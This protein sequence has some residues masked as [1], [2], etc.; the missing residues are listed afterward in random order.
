MNAITRPLLA[1]GAAFLWALSALAEIPENFKTS[2]LVAWCVAHRWDSENRSPAERAALLSELGIGRIA[3]NWRDADNP[4]FEA[5]ILECRKQGI[6]YFAF[7]NEN[8]DAFALFEKHGLRPQIWKTCPS[9]NADTQ[10]ERVAAAARRMLPFAKRAKA[11][12]SPF[13][14]YNHRN[15][16]GHPDNLIA[17]CKELRRQGCDNVGI[18]YNFHHSHDEMDRFEEYLDAMLP[19]LL[20]INLNGMADKDT[21][22]HKTLEN[23]IIPVGSGRHEMAMIKSVIKSGY[24]GPIGILDHI[25]SQDT[26]KSLRDNLEGL[27]SIPALMQDK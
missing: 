6:E 1:V 2:N 11:L 14:L 18:V 23:K 27:K 3:Y 25:E 4:D 8:E 21:V 10:A 16:G 12:G 26:A 17:V 15:W 13:G 19:Y 7:W 20:C 22:N 9:P 24:K 5:E